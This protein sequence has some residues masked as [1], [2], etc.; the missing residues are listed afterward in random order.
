MVD[1]SRSLQTHVENQLAKKMAEAQYRMGLTAATE[2]LVTG[3]FTEESIA[4]ATE[5]FESLPGL[6]TDDRLTH[7]IVAA[8][9]WRL[10]AGPDEVMTPVPFDQGID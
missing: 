9:G 2:D 7:A 5:V 3:L 1:I 6:P 4:R 8:L 10:V